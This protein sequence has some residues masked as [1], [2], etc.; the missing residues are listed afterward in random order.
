M[1]KRAGR[2]GKSK[3]A[4]KKNNGAVLGF[5]ETLWRAADKLRHNMDA[6]EYKHVVLG[7]IFLKYISDAFQERYNEL[8][9]EE[10][11]NPEDR[12]E[13]LAEN[14]VWDPLDNPSS[15]PLR[16]QNPVK[17]LDHAKR[18]VIAARY[19]DI[20]ADAVMQATG[21]RQEDQRG[22]FGVNYD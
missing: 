15:E 19:Y 20:P 9:A 4:G 17:H 7:L 13:Y 12:D 3:K 1:A 11:A 6:A 10:Y 14:V 18:E 22:Q 8:Q 16:I 21:R 5:E 2:S